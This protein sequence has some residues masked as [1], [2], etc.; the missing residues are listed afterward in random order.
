MCLSSSETISSGVIWNDMA[1]RLAEGQ[2][3][4]AAPD[5]GDCPD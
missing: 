4:T 1:G 3:K 2:K 5:A